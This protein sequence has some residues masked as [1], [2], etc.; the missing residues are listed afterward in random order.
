MTN[1]SLMFRSKVLIM[2]IKSIRGLVDSYWDECSLCDA[3]TAGP[4]CGLCR[5]CYI[6]ENGTDEGWE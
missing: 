4:E 2:E 5:D 1:V 3:P 6:K